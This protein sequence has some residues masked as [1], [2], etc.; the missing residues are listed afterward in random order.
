VG[1]GGLGALGEGDR[2]LFEPG[3]L[4]LVEL[5]RSDGAALLASLRAAAFLFLLGALLRTLP[6]AVLFRA[7]LG[8]EASFAES[9]VSA[10]PQ[11]VRFW[12]LALLELGGKIVIFG[13]G[14]LIAHACSDFGLAPK[15]GPLS[16]WIPAAAALLAFATV[17]FLSIVL[18]VARACSTRD[19]RALS[20]VLDQSLDLAKGALADLVPGYLVRVGLGVFTVAACAR[21]VEV[22]DVGRP[23]AFRPWLVGGLHQA[24][25]AGLCLI[26]GLWAARVTAVVERSAQPQTAG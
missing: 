22:N 17:A 1:A 12:V 5:L 3:G 7:A 15:E 16:V 6:L 8:A 10:L 11:L 14:A 9:V 19:E 2:A 26:Q 20:R 23:G 24:V 4:W 13:L 21:L 25:I 18:D